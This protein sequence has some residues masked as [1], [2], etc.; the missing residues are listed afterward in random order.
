[1]KSVFT[2]K[3]VQQFKEQGIP[4]EEVERQLER[5]RRGFPYADIRKPAT[6]GDGI[7]TLS[8]QEGDKLVRLYEEK[9]REY[10]VTKFVP[11]SGAASRMFKSLFAFYDLCVSAAKQGVSPSLP[12]EVKVFFDGLD[13][14]AFYGALKHALAEKGKDIRSLRQ[15]NHYKD[16]LEALLFP[17]GLE[18]GSLPKGLILFH[19]YPGHNRTAFEEHL[20]EG[21][22]HVEDEQHNS[23]AHFTVSP[24]HMEKFRKKMEEVHA[25]FE[26]KFGVRYKISYSVQKPSTD[27][28]AVTPENH[29]F[30]LPDGK[31]LFRPGGHGA[32]IENLNDRGEDIIFIKNID[33]VVPDR[34]KGDTVRYKKI[35]GGLLIRLLRKIYRWLNKMDGKALDEQEMNELIAFVVRELQTELP[36]DFS[37]LSPSG[38]QKA[39]YE[40]LHRPVRV[41][42]MVKNEGEPGGGPFW[43]AGKDGRLSLQIV[44]SSQINRDDP[45]K[46]EILNH[47]THFNPVDLVCAVKD[48]QG[49]KYD[50]KAFV[51]P[52]TYFISSKSFDGKELKALELPGLWNGAMADW[53]TLFV[54]VPASTFHPV[55]TVNDLLR[56]EHLNE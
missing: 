31:I 17:S 11:A 24:E 22:M 38:K 2:G 23:Y 27:T 13:R 5:F 52:E 47:S 55:K 43:V 34:L 21:A 8:Q 48:H 29:P 56:P 25:Y 49:R 41:C 19:R 18:Y 1:M 26:G 50:L 4:V 40:I 3:D 10:R 7:L 46:N 28:I 54:E 6:P 53:I 16:I 36:G 39:V 15:T 35:L 14:F 12:G 44:E 45:Q 51:D 20:A 42:G 9:S 33:N 30:R 32:L 37:A